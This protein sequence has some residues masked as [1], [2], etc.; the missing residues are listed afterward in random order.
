MSGALVDA[1]RPP[2]LRQRGRR[3]ESRDPA[4]GDLRVT[5]AASRYF[6]LDAPSITV[7]VDSSDVGSQSTSAR[8]TP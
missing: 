3:H 4:A 6:F 8:L 7:D 5:P 1:H 2:T